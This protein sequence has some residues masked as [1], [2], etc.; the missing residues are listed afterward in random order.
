M[1][2]QVS[3]DDS[4]LN[5]LNTK[6][7]DKQADISSL[8]KKYLQFLELAEV[9]I[10]E[11]G[12][13]GEIL[14]INGKVQEI[15]EYHPD[16]LV[17]KNWF[18]TCL[19]ESEFSQVSQVYQDLL[20]GK[21][22]PVKYYENEVITKTGKKRFIRWNNSIQKDNKG[23]IIGTLSSGID[24]TDK[25]QKEQLAK[26]RELMLA[27]VQETAHIGTWDWDTE[28]NT[29]VFSP[30]L[31]EIY[32]ISP[33]KFDGEIEPIINNIMH[34]DDREIVNESI[35]K[36]LQS[37]EPHPIEFRIILESGELRYLWGD[38]TAIYNEHGLRRMIGFIQDITERRNIE[39]AARM[40]EA[41]F[42][43]IID[44]SPVPFA[45]NDIGQN[46]T[47]LNPAFL[48]TF[49]YDLS[50]IPTLND[51][52]P[53]AYPDENYRNWVSNTWAERLLAS[54][55]SGKEFEPLE[56]TIHCKD[57]S[58]KIV[59]AGASP[60]SGSYDSDHLVTLYDVTESRQSEKSLKETQ[61]LLLNTEALAKVGSWEWE[62]SSNWVKWSPE[63]YNIYQYDPVQYSEM[64]FEIA[65]RRC[66]PEDV[67]YIEANVK[68]ALESGVS[69]TN[70][71]RIVLDDGSIRY[72][73][74]NIE[75][76]TDTDGNPVSLIGFVQDVSERVAAEAAL[77]EGNK[78][79]Q[80]LFEQSS[81]GVAKIDSQT[82]DFI[83][84]NQ[85]Y[86]DILGY[87]VEEMLVT[88]FQNITLSE[89]L[90]D[91]LKNMARL[92]AGEISSFQM[93]K[94]YVHRNGDIIWVNLSVLPMW[95]VGETPDYHIAIVENITLRKQAESKLK[96][97]QEEQKQ[98]IQNIGVALVA[99]DEMGTIDTF[100]EAAHIKFGYKHQ[101]IL[102]QNIS[103]LIP[104]L[105][106][107]QLP[108]TISWLIHEK[109]NKNLPQ[110]VN[111]KRLS[112]ELFPMNI[113]FT[114]MP[115]L[116][117]SG[118]RYIAAC[119]D[120]SLEKQ[121]EEQ[122]RRS[123]KMDA[124]GKL[125]GGIAHDYNNMLGV[126]S[127]YSL[128]LDE[129]LD[130]QENLKNYTAEILR[131]SDRASS[132]SR[133][134]LA[135][136]RNIQSEA[137]IIN[138]NN[139]LC[140]EQD[141]LEKTLT[142]RIRL[143]ID[144]QQGIWPIYVNGGDLED[145]ILNLGINAMHAMPT[146][147]DFEITVRNERYS[148]ADNPFVNIDDG[149]Y[150]TLTVSDTGCGI[151]PENMKNIFDPFFTTKG[152]EGVGLG[153]STVYGFVKR[154]NG[155][156]L[157]ESKLDEGTSFHI[158]FPRCSEVIE[159]EK[160]ESH[161]Q[162]NNLH[163]KET[164]LVVDDELALVNMS[165][166]MLTAKGYKVL[167]ANSGEEALEMLQRER[168]DLV[169][170]DVI[171]PHMDGYQLAEE[172][173][174]RFPSV[175]VQLVSGYT[176]PRDNVSIDRELESSILSKPFTDKQLLSAVRQMLNKKHLLNVKNK[177]VVLI[178]DDDLTAQELYRM[179]LSKLGYDICTASDGDE[180]TRLYR[181]YMNTQKTIDVA[182]LDLNI[183]GGKDGLTTAK[184][185]IDIDPGVKIIIASGDTENDLMQN[186]AN[187]GFS[188]ALE[189]D[190][191][192][193]HMKETLEKVL[194]EESTL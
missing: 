142:P 192:R 110:E 135:F 98:L 13:L 40:G 27:K 193:K 38:V 86:C 8:N 80:A 125:T 108:E 158:A 6:L 132:L 85:R 51:W 12:K 4:E 53:K 178:M 24:I 14:S 62:L 167:T 190:F 144:I 168:I 56:L 16:E 70:E 30:E 15:L 49:G 118:R 105:E 59:I 25:K 91:D 33:E 159:N 21:I 149:D 117:R 71:Y 136:S 138:I 46:I 112:G 104:S 88:N 181:K 120:I 78:R 162:L 161:S 10:V 143:K 113:Y 156:I 191:N 35:A 44:A 55:E 133:K 42:H 106:G 189:K 176:N 92:K 22:E 145:A 37:G 90:L 58:E 84:I 164:I 26:E 129:Q 121:Q 126:I 187:Y 123:Q 96:E 60:L 47:Y 103:H 43:S 69:V 19:P 137:E 140:S 122:L 61:Q 175:L 68:K 32:G 94:R 17:G 74:A 163:G 115:A 18:A 185:L 41:H 150:V 172:I 147:G 102:K 39:N 65:M 109:Q 148:G 101:E 194:S 7:A 107:K 81:F 97:Q 183:D 174:A 173:K 171:M 54:K 82:G 186:Y 52:W 128:L 170:S 29:F 79:F 1:A 83:E 134:L 48:K 64:N 169:V 111:G 87:T 116:K 155:E 124:L 177:P 179:N 11:L 93:E 182:I 23:N 31:L 119:Y 73:W 114:E 146:G 130:G 141:M 180:A 152:E 154:S 165:K 57:G 153:L 3:S 166:Q 157:V 63:M 34:P 100:N 184:E 188:A 151:P 131:A 67:E 99:F 28:S 9:L 76:N 66:H 127:G 45:L 160:S 20:S 95:N 77:H 89:D 36:S 50:D 72:L 75:L 139:L 2:A 5:L